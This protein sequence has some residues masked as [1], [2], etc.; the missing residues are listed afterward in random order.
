MSFKLIA[1]MRL[2]SFYKPQELNKHEDTE[3]QVPLTWHHITKLVT[4][5]GY[6][7]ILE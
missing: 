3:D 2:K 1:S 6:L 5:A 4:Q 7:A